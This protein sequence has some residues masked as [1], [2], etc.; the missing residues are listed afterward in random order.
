[1]IGEGDAA[2]GPVVPGVNNEVLDARQD[3]DRW[4]AT[5]AD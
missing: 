3:P 2:P 4:A 5:L 1:L